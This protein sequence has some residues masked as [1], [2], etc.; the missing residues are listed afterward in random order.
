M[1]TQCNLS[2][3]SFSCCVCLEDNKYN[4]ED[5][6][7][8]YKDYLQWVKKHRT[9]YIQSPIALHI[10]AKHHKCSPELYDSVRQQAIEKRGLDTYPIACPVLGCAER[11]IQNP[12]SHKLWG[13]LVEICKNGHLIDFDCYHKTMLNR[14]TS[15]PLCREPIRLE[16]VHCIPTV[17]I[18]S[19]HILPGCRALDAMGAFLDLALVEE[20]ARGTGISKDPLNEDESM[21][22]LVPREYVSYEDFPSMIRE[23]F[24]DTRHNSP[25]PGMR[26]KVALVF[27]LA[28]NTDDYMILVELVASFLKDWELVK[29]VID[30]VIPCGQLA[31]Y[32]IK[33]N[34]VQTLIAIQ[35]MILPNNKLH[36]NVVQKMQ[37]VLTILR[38]ADNFVGRKWLSIHTEEQD[39][40]V[41]TSVID[42][43]VPDVPALPDVANSSGPIAGLPLPPD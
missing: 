3:T 17:P 23:I 15:C 2:P 10:C 6:P 20:E 14:I 42:E 22:W 11:L 5:D 29:G 25:L 28:Q 9:N 39:T 31:F 33:K 21:L 19:P 16:S 24:I 30:V 40:H 34:L 12:T 32:K 7:Q 43:V 18:I 37:L 4:E 35:C 27:I 13:F 36:E 1:S 26:E 41:Y 38:S 8:T